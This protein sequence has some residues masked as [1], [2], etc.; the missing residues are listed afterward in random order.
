MRNHGWRRRAINFLTFGD[1]SNGLKHPL[2]EE[3]GHQ[4]LYYHLNQKEYL[5]ISLPEVEIECSLQLP[6]ISNPQQNGK[7]FLI[8]IIYSNTIYNFMLSR[9]INRNYLF[10]LID[11]VK[12]T[13]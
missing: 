5:F 9:M 6:N 8:H 7:K 2:G 10:K 3:K 11:N 12:L 4:I 13:I 1:P